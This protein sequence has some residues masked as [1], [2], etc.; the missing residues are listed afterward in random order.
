MKTIELTPE[1]RKRTISALEETQRHLRR[2]LGYSSDLQK[3][4]EI[5]LYMAHQEKL[6]VYLTTG[7]VTLHP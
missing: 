7:Q 5:T 2:E 3:P 6:V 4:E 1:L